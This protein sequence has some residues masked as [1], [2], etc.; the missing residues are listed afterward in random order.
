VVQIFTRRGEGDMKVSGSA[1]AGTDSYRKLALSIGGQ[2]GDSR[3]RFGAA[4]TQTDGFSSV[5]C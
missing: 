2:A 4:R 1:S 5:R 3:V